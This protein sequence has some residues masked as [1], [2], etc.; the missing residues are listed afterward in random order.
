MKKLKCSCGKE[1]DSYVNIFECTQC[2][3]IACF[4]CSKICPICDCRLHIT[5]F[6][7]SKKYG[8]KGICWVCK[9]EKS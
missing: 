8:K 4:E 7:K 6:R 5:H 1:Y 9:E 2:G 3:K